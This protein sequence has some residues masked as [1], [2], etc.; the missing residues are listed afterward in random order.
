MYSGPV[1][2]MVPA[3]NPA[4]PVIVPVQA[5]SSNR[6]ATG[7]VATVLSAPEDPVAG[8]AMLC[9]AEVPEVLVAD[10]VV[11]L[12]EVPA[13]PVEGLEGR[14]VALAVLSKDKMSEILIF[15]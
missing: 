6:E 9:L 2:L 11:V 15:F 5:T 4:F 13:D 3:S 14:V 1:R 7:R 10:P 8:P 12:V